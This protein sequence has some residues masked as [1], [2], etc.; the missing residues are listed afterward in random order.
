MQFIQRDEASS[1]PGKDAFVKIEP[2]KSVAG[3]FRGEPYDFKMHWDNAAKRSSTCTQDE[4]CEKCKAGDKPRFRFRLNFVTRDPQTKERVV[5][6]FEQSWQT[7]QTLA[8]LQSAGYN[9]ERT[10]IQITRIG[11]GK[12]TKYTLAPLPPDKGGA[13]SDAQ[14]KEISQLKLYDLANP[15]AGEPR[16]ESEEADT[17]PF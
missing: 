15:E 4:T 6:I 5:R 8:A 14:E 13:V 3:V 12:E 1:G 10:G 7:Y 16:G 9:L 17:V 2:G 11:E